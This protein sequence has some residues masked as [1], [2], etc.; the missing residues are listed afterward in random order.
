ML[1]V[2]ALVV[3]Y[4]YVQLS[5]G[6]ADEDGR[7][8]PDR[9]EA[10]V[11][12]KGAHERRPS[13]AERAAADRGYRA[14]LERACRTDTPAVWDDGWTAAGRSR[15][16]MAKDLDLCLRFTWATEYGIA[17]NEACSRP[18][19]AASFDERWRRGGM[20]PEGMA[21][22]VARCRQRAG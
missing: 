20:T 6:A 13:G 15:A 9:R 17:V 11:E 21:A 1:A 12:V 2:V 8:A 4:F 7:V 10:P 18:T 3:V 19:G 14:E 5:G 16:G 22:D